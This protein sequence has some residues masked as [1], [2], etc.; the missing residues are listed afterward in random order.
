[1]RIFEDPTSGSGL[2]KPLSCV[3]TRYCRMPGSRPAE[4]ALAGAGG[5]RGVEPTV[6]R[7][8]HVVVGAGGVEPGLGNIGAGHRAIVTYS[9]K[10]VG[11]MSQSMSRRYLMCWWAP[12][13]P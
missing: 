7:A 9:L 10:A 2:E 12:S 6:A 3:S 13:L 11:S 5:G 8:G 1:M 4:V